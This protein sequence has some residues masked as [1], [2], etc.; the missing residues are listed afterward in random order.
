MGNEFPIVG[1]MQ[2]DW[3][4]VFL[5]SWK[6]QREA[7]QTENTPSTPW[8][9]WFLTIR[10]GGRE[11]AERAEPAWGLR[12]AVGGGL[13]LHSPDSLRLSNQVPRPTVQIVSRGQA[14]KG[15]G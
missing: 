9:V 12:P 13:P 8:S 4:G 2:A 14:G 11:R 7:G 6:H 5:V 10:A 15:S 3:A 1:S